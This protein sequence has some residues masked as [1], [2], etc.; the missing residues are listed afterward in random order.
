MTVAGKS[1]AGQEGADSGIRYR[2]PGRA[3]HPAG[4]ALEDR[5]REKRRTGPLQRAHPQPPPPRFPNASR[6][7]LRGVGSDNMIPAPV[8]S[9]PQTDRWCLRL[10]TIMQ[11][12]CDTPIPLW[13]RGRSLRGCCEWVGMPIMG[14]SRFLNTDLACTEPAA[15]SSRIP[16]VP[17][18]GGASAQSVDGSVSWSTVPSQGWSAA[19]GQREVIDQ[20]VGGHRAGALQVGGGPAVP[21]RRGAGRCRT[22]QPGRPEG[23]DHSCQHISCPDG[24]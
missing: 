4:Q 19:G 22:V 10:L 15:G 7:P 8:R 17:V 18:T 5:E 1:T 6:H 13:R 20:L 3:D 14:R 21:V 16:G 24:G 23:S 2:Y 12:G 11:R 9:V